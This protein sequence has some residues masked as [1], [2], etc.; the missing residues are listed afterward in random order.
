LLD[1]TTL[2]AGGSFSKIHGQDRHCLAAID[3]T[4]AQPTSW[5]PQPNDTV[6]TLA[7][8]GSTLYAGGTFSSV[9]GVARAHLAAVDSVTGQPTTFAPNADGVVQALAV[10]A[11][12]LYA[13]GSF[14]SVGGAP[15]PY[16]AAVATAN[17]LVTPWNPQA[18]D[19]VD[20]LALQGEIVYAGGSFLN[21]GGQTRYRAAALSTTSSLATAWDSHPNGAVHALAVVGTRI[22]VG[23]E[24]TDITS[25][26]LTGI[27]ALDTRTAQPDPAFNANA[28][29][30]VNVIVP[31]GPTIYVA[32][33]F[34]AIGGQRFHY[35]SEL[36]ASDG[37]A[38]TWNPYATS[39]ISVVAMAGT[40]LLVG[41]DFSGIG[42]GSFDYLADVSRATGVARNWNP[43]VN[44]LVNA[45]SNVGPTTFW[46][47][48]GFTTV[49]GAPRR[50]L[51]QFD[52]AYSVR[53]VTDGTSG[54]SIVGD[55]NQTVVLGAEA[56]SVTA[57]APPGF[58]FT[59]WTLAGAFYSKANPL[60]V[61]DVQRDMV[62]VAGFSNLYTLTFATDGTP[63]AYVQGATYQTLLPGAD[64][65][66]VTA[67]DPSDD[68]FLKWNRDGAFYSTD[69][70]ID[71]LNVQADMSF[72]A[73]YSGSVYTVT[74]GTG[75]VPGTTLTGTT[76]QFI[77]LGEDCTPVRVN[78]PHGYRFAKWLSNGVDYSWVNPV[79]VTGVTGGMVL[80]PV[81]APDPHVWIVK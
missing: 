66:T 39:V 55:T 46:V 21:I 41:G 71:V 19:E 61:T 51:A 81:L 74:F 31:A 72:V 29:G 16:I 11:T 67:V 54:T 68:H 9:G 80:T 50:G 22:Y 13:G 65:T 52:A 70:T 58:H 49:G 30:A 35:F 28:N 60:T 45:I 3:T 48:G 36:N 73:V 18:N 26:S 4:S 27:A 37:T 79:T 78:P 77:L 76:P 1:G 8:E 2:Y 25:T 62:L 40:D 23:G 20:S 12:T 14:H 43:A 47:G 17:G 15:R 33:G 24:F 5:A 7:L 64:A 44:G 75:N 34:L 57:V 63:G 10:N 59:N 38:T 42:N 6:L 69:R 32:G 56:T 53:F